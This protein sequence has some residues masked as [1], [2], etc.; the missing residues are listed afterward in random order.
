MVGPKVIIIVVI[1]IVIVF[2]YSQSRQ[3][4]YIAQTCFGENVIEKFNVSIGA[5][6]P[7]LELSCFVDP[8]QG[9]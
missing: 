9:F 3:I 1:I 4:Y 6:D 8:E 2:I 7:V 5:N